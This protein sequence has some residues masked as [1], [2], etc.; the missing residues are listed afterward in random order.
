MAEQYYQ[1]PQTPDP[2]F[3]GR[4]SLVAPSH[5]PPPITPTDDRG[6]GGGRSPPPDGAQ[7]HLMLITLTAHKTRRVNSRNSKSIKGRP[8]AQTVLLMPGKQHPLLASILPAGKK[9]SAWSIMYGE[10]IAVLEDIKKSIQDALDRLIPEAP[11]QPSTPEEEDGEE[12]LLAKG[13]CTKR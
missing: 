10:A 11:T 5:T 7:P 9:Y 3:I 6:G 13:T 1:P 8:A 4:S 2:Q 12:E